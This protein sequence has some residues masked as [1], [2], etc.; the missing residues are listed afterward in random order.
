MSL[1]TFFL[2]KTF[3]KKLE[4]QSQ[5]QYII[6]ESYLMDYIRHC[7]RN[8]LSEINTM[9]KKWTS[10]LGHLFF[11]IILILLFYIYKYM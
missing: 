1:G 4:L 2:S 8:N 3:I 7:V 5:H 6:H 11:N 10:H 9:E